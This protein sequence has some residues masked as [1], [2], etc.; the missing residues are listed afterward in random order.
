MVNNRGQRRNKRKTQPRNGNQRQMIARPIAQNRVHLQRWFTMDG[1]PEIPA[2]QTVYS[3]SRQVNAFRFPELQ[4]YMTRYQ[5]FVV[6]SIGARFM[7]G[8]ENIMGSVA[9]KVVTR[10]TYD[11]LAVP[12]TVNHAWLKTNGCKVT[13]CRSQANSPPNTSLVKSVHRA[14]PSA[15]NNQPGSS[16]GFVWWVFEGP[17]DQNARTHLGEIEVFLD[18]IFDGL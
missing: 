6:N 8:M 11:A 9:I 18:I 10:E 17:Q 15:G 1:K 16:V 5:T 2:N 14:V 3:F 7:S 12:G 13:P 4:D